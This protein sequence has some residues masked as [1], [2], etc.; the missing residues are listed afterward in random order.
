MTRDAR[1]GAG[2]QDRDGRP[3]HPEVHDDDCVE[4]GSASS[5]DTGS[6]FKVVGSTSNKTGTAPNWAAGWAVAANVQVGTPTRAPG[7]RR[8]LAV[9][10]SV[11]RCTTAPTRLRAPPAE[12][13]QFVLE[14]HAFVAGREPSAPQ[15]T[16]HRCLVG[17]T[18]LRRGESDQGVSR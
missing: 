13:S 1:C 14:L 11:L 7:R 3:G 6:T 8:R 4:M 12:C 16:Q 15:G 10:M 2:V 9:A 18:H 5:S 17:R